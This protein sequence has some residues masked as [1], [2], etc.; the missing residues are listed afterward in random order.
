MAPSD[1]LDDDFKSNWN[2]IVQ[3]QRPFDGVPRSEN[4]VMKISSVARPRPDQAKPTVLYTVY[5]Y[6]EGSAPRSRR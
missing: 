2:K 5:H 4:D 6:A 3:R 1:D